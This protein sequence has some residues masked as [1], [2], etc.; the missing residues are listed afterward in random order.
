M[1]LRNLAFTL[2]LAVTACTEDRITGLDQ[3]V[4]SLNATGAFGAPRYVGLSQFDTV[5][6]SAT[7]LP[8]PFVC[9]Y[10]NA[11]GAA[12]AAAV[13]HIASLTLWP[14]GTARWYARAYG[15]QRAADGSVVAGLDANSDVTRTGRWRTASPGRIALAGLGT[16]AP[17]ELAYTELGSYEVRTTVPCP[18]ISG[19]ETRTVTVSLGAGGD[20]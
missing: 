13:L 3:P 14:D 19:G 5:N 17:T 1:R 12:R 7:R 18:A 15:W 11:T 2:V 9:S 20:R 8:A 16:G 6:T 4:L 10:P